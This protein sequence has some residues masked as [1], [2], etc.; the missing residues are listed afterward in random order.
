MP[1]L[2]R[3]L[4]TSRRGRRQAAQFRLEPLELRHLMTIGPL[5]SG[6]PSLIE[7]EPN[8]T[9]DLAQS[10]GDLNVIPSLKLS[11]KIGNSG[12]GPADVDWYEFT[13]DGP[14]RV[15]FLASP[16][17]STPGFHPVLSLYN[18][19]PFDFQDLYNPTGR[20]LLIQADSSAHQGLAY[21]DTQL[22]AGTYHLA[23]SGA[24]NLYFN[25]L[26]AASGFPGQTGGYELTVSATSIPIQSGDGPFVLTASPGVGSVSSSSPLAIRI[27]FSGA[28]D[29]GTIAP[30]QTVQLL[31]SPSGT[32]DQNGQDVALWQVNFAGAVNELQLF[33]TQALAPGTYEVRL[34]GQSSDSLPVLTDLWGIPLGADA[35]HPH[36]QDFVYTFQVDGIDG[37]VG[38][39]AKA[40]DTPATAHELGDVASRSFFQITGAIGADPFYD[41]S[42]WD[43]LANP[44]NDVNLYHF[45]IVGPGRYALAAEVFAGRIGS[46]LDP[47]V[48][49]YWLAPDGHTLNLVAGNNNTNNWTP[50]T[51]SSSP[52]ALDAAMTAG[53]VAGDYYIAVSSGW[54]TPSVAEHQPL[55]TPGLF[56]PTVSHSGSIGWGTGE[57]V[58]NLLVR[59][60]L[61]PPQVIASNPFPGAVLSQSPT[62]LT[63]RFS[64]PVNLNELALAAY[65]P[66]TGEGDMRAVSI[67]AQNGA[68][69]HPRLE[70]YNAETN[71]AT[72]L[73]LDRLPSGN[74]TLHLSG[75]G[76][77]ADLAGN[78]LV[79]N[80]PG[81]DYVVMFTVQAAES[82]VSGDS[83]QGY[84]IALPS[85]S[86]EPVD[87]GV[88]F[89]H[90]WQTGIDL[91]RSLEQSPSS[92][93]L[94]FSDK[95]KFDVLQEK[96]YTFTSVGNDLPEGIHL[97]LTDGAGNAVSYYSMQ[98]GRV[99]VALLAPGAYQLNVSGWY[100][101]AEARLAYRLHL[102][103]RDSLDNPPALASGPSPALMLHFADSSPD[104]LSPRPPLTSG[105]VPSGPL[106][107]APTGATDPVNG[108]GNQLSGG[109]TPPGSDSNG[110][111]PSHSSVG[112]SGTLTGGVEFA[113]LGVGPLGGAG[114]TTHL[115]PQPSP[116]QL[117]GSAASSLSDGLLSL[118]VPG[119]SQSFELP[120]PDDFDPGNEARPEFVASSPSLTWNKLD[121]EIVPDLS[122]LRA[123]GRD[124]L[125]RKAAEQVIAGETVT[126]PREQA[127]PPARATELLAG[128]AELSAGTIEVEEASM[129]PDWM[130][131]SALAGLISFASVKLSRWRTRVLLRWNRPGCLNGPR[132][133]WPWRR[134][135]PS[136]PHLKLDQRGGCA[137]RQSRDYASQVEGGH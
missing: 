128:L 133:R 2:S 16:G 137:R 75:P 104:V 76:G 46:P 51:D 17:Q 43:P 118:L 112:L 11:G 55:N 77:L 42:S 101:T 86:S 130:V 6:A 68:R 132:S 80:E 111:A 30:G 108:G 50:A 49:L 105:G 12:D 20:R 53:L 123:I 47:G 85:G 103:V 106:A 59:P 119:R 125:S 21:I 135:V 4:F 131:W 102:D 122:G 89:P 48:S 41:F 33:P 69:F 79:G 35:E 98:G 65:D 40:D 25:P 110:A 100:P 109:Q 18:N 19:D 73:M 29:P 63:V 92:A 120:S 70:S 37:N 56:D 38:P 44:G 121:P 26:L 34:V 91:I 72:F 14:S 81:G 114:T 22:A 15:V 115:G 95:L 36:G 62:R 10:V 113:S 83:S 67:E 107:Q 99:L 74:Y 78:P 52:L 39:A 60:V 7:L 9:V 84:E 127:L 134:T 82:P 93:A 126:V 88:L 117:A 124:Q 116:A 97:S 57:Y 32:I 27:S 136:K 45:R 24:G 87:L 54:N 23:L 129:V 71:T 94:E 28:L 58:L 90:E 31:H 8:G 96:F 64:D 5:P 66:M 13:L 61:N 3:S 1:A